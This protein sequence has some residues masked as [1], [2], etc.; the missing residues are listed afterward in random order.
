MQKG[1]NKNIQE[2]LGTVRRPNLRNIGIEKSE[3]LQLKSPVNIFSKIIEENF[4]K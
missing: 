4:Q 3:D 1:Y 2:I